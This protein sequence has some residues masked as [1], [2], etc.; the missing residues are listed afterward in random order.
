MHRN[1]LDEKAYRQMLEADWSYTNGE[2]AKLSADTMSCMA[3]PVLDVTGK[4]A[5]GVIYLDSKQPN[6]FDNEDM[7]NGIFESS[8]GV[9]RYVSE[10]YGK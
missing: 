4:H 3:V 6:L 9:T 2:A 8:A 5:L 1:D 10:R 7:Q